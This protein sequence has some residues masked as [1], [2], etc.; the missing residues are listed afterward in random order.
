[1]RDPSVPFRDKNKVGCVLSTMR[2]SRIRVEVSILAEEMGQA[3]WI[4][5]ALQLTSVFYSWIAQGFFLLCSPYGVWG[6]IICGASDLTG[7]S[8]LHGKHPATPCTISPPL[9]NIFHSLDERHWLNGVLGWH[10]DTY[11][12][13]RRVGQVLCTVSS[14][15]PGRTWRLRETEQSELFRFRFFPLFPI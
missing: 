12:K 9:K 5:T 13:V 15:C 4:S 8:H 10:T 7:V 3:S 14:H 11:P 6:I 2:G 1:M